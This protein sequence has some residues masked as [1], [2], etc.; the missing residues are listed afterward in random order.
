M[1]EASRRYPKGKSAA[2]RENFQLF[3][4]KEYILR[5]K[6]CQYPRNPPAQTINLPA[7]EEQLS[8]IKDIITRTIPVEQ[9]YLLLLVMA[10]SPR[11]IIF[12]PIMMSNSRSLR[13]SIPHSVRL[14]LLNRKS[15]R[16]T[17]PF[18]LLT[19]PPRSPWPTGL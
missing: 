8:I 4:R 3:H 11:L 10:K 16:N 13:A 5:L 9:I 14:N 6:V 2:A 18:R 7:V 17:I 12:I 1:R 15:A 19:A